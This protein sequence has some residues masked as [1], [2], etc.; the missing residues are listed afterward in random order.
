VARFSVNGQNFSNINDPS[1]PS[2]Y[3]Y[4]F[5]VRGGQEVTMEA[6]DY[7]CRDDDAWAGTGRTISHNG[8]TFRVARCTDIKA[9]STVPP[10]EIYL[11]G[12]DLSPLV[13]TDYDDVWQTDID[14]AFA[15]YDEVTLNGTT[16]R[17]DL[18][19]NQALVYYD[20]PDGSESENYLLLLYEI[21]IA[22]SDA[23][24]AGTVNVVVNNV[25][26]DE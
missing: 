11:D 7:E 23:R 10:D 19:S 26:F 21:G 15:E 18:K 2:P 1:T 17:V 20:L 22:E 4:I 14:N 25:E 13:A 5:S 8:T 12:D 9:S 16:G 24:A 3:S 6:Y